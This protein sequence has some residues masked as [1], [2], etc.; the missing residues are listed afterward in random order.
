MNGTYTVKE[1]NEGQVWEDKIKQRNSVDEARTQNLISVVVMM[2]L[3]LAP[4]KSVYTI[5]VLSQYPHMEKNCG[6]LQNKNN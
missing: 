5:H 3:G 2:T 4:R 6:R 1:K